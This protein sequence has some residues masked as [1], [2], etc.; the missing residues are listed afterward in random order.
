MRIAAWSKRL[1]IWLTLPFVWFILL[2]LLVLF[3]S[4]IRVTREIR[5]IDAQLEIIHHQ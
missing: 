4:W 5:A 2:G 1:F 3:L